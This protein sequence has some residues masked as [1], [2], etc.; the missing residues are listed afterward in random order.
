LLGAGERRGPAQP[1]L[2]K[3]RPA[4]TVWSWSANALIRGP[5]DTWRRAACFMELS[6]STGRFRRT[7]TPRSQASERFLDIGRNLSVVKATFSELG[8]S[9]VSGMIG[10]V[11]TFSGRPTMRDVAAL[12]GVSLAT[13][14]RVVNESPA[15]DAEL[16]ERVRAAAGKLSYRRDETA[17]ALRRAD[18]VSTSVGLIIEDIGNQFFSVVHRGFEDVA[19]ARGVLVFS[20]SSDDDPERERQLADA[21]AARRVDGLVIVPAGTDQSYLQRDRQAGLPLVFVDRPP[22]FIDADAVLSDNFGGAR[23]A[24]SHL[25]SAGHRRIGYLGDRERIFTAAERLRGHHHAL[26]AVGIEPDPSLVRME[27]PDSASA[28]A[29]ARELLLQPAPPT[30]LVTG[31]NLITVGAVHALRE[32]SLQHRVALVAFDEVPLSDLLEPGITTVAQDP[33]CLGRRAAELLFERLDGAREPS[34]RV[35]VPV[36][37]VPRG[38]GE[39]PA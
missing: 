21:F 10:G 18:R 32:L 19:R 12:A 34:R 30:A 9:A 1:A 3:V 27:L 17:S 33:I 22:R 25:L 11:Q 15:V 7:G 23:E 5:V 8:R 13:V 38:S 26:A 24:T 6:S 20:G 36:R 16:A 29:A 37:L 39:I 14:S 28:R 4:I 2:E 31:Q 35:I